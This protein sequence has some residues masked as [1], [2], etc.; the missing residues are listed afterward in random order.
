MIA[1][2]LNDSPPTSEAVAAARAGTEGGL[3]KYIPALT[4]AASSSGFWFGI[5]LYNTH[6]SAE[7]IASILG[8]IISTRWAADANIPTLP[9]PADWHPNGRVG[10]MDRA[11]GVKRK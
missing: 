11:A 7:V 5:A 3:M 6:S 4:S 10:G 9:F 2:N 1:T 8:V